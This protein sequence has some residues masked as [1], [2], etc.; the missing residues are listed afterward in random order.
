MHIKQVLVTGG[1]GFIGSQ[2]VLDLLER[3]YSVRALDDLSTGKKENLKTAFGHPQ[4]EYLEGSIED[5]ALLKRTLVGCDAVLHLAV[6]NL[7]LS[8]RNPELSHRVNATGTLNV[9]EASHAEGVKR[10]IYLSSSEIYG[11]ALTVPMAVDHPKNPETVYASS[12]LAGEYYTQNYS[13]MY[14]MNATI[15]R[16]F[17][18]YGPRSHYEGAN[19][20]FI[21]RSVIRLLNGLAPVIFGNGTQTRDFIYVADTSRFILSVLENQ[22]LNG[23]TLNCS[24]GVETSIKD[25]AVKLCKMINPDIEPH[26]VPVERPGDVQRHCG[27]STGER[28]LLNY[29]PYYDLDKG[30]KQYLHWIEG[31]NFDLKAKLSEIQETNW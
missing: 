13:K 19:G 30:L 29:S 20:E 21:P 11:T 18:N 28:K 1:A 27:D 5:K 26:F 3:G 8:I 4:F 12:K 6:S 25:L 7:R 23:K 17:N 15:I 10:F 22:D 31:Q 24:T 16:P 9:L 14:G 2:V